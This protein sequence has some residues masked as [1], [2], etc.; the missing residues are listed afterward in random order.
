MVKINH[1][2]KL[3]NKH[4]I[5]LIELFKIVER[6]ESPFENNTHNSG[7]NNQ[8]CQRQA[9]ANNEF[10]CIS[11]PSP[12]HTHIRSCF[13]LF[14]TTIRKYQLFIHFIWVHE[15]FIRLVSQKYCW[16]NISF[17][18]KLHSLKSNVVK[19]H[20]QERKKSS[21]SIKLPFT[22]WLHFQNLEHIPSSLDF[23]VLFYHSLAHTQSVIKKNFVSLLINIKVWATICVW[24]QQK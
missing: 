17:P 12:D 3:R 11:F 20:K 16:E 13:C 5:D 23:E 8:I 24:I 2:C 1:V 15:S 7:N 4:F 22:L 6:F 21:I 9:K 10:N 14:F 19:L 18:I